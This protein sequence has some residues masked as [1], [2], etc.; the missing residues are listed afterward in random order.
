MCPPHDSVFDLETGSV[1]DWVP[2]P[3]VVGRA[4]GA[5]SQQSA[6]P[7]DPTKIDDAGTWVGIEAQDE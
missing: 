1:K 3:P 6:L 2:W 7:V 5:I 4:L